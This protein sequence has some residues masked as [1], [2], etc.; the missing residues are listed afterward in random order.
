MAKLFGF[1]FGRVEPTYLKQ[2]KVANDNVSF[3]DREADSTAAVVLATP[4]ST[5]TFVDLTGN[6]KTEAEF[7]SKYREMMNQPEVDN[8]VSEIINE[9]VC[10]DKEFVVKI[11]LGGVPLEEQSK[12]VIKE[13]FDELI[14]LLDFDTMAYDIFKRWYVDGRLYYHAVIDPK[15]PQEGI[16]EFRYID[17]RK[18]REIKEVKQ[19]PVPGGVAHQSAEVTI[20]KN[21]YY[22]YNEKGFTNTGKA[23]V[24]QNPSTGGIRISKDSV[25]HVPSGLTD[26]NG[27]VGLSYLHK[28]IKILNELRTI[29]DAIII[30][31]LARAPERRVWKVDCGTLP[32]MKARQHLQE[33]MNLQKNRLIYDADTGT[34]RD[35][36]KFMCYSLDTKIPLLDGRTL[37]LQEIMKEY[38][39]GKQNWVYS[40]DPI[41]GKFVPGP[42]SW[43]GITKRNSEVVRVTFD[44]GQSVVC[45]PDHKFPVWNKGFIEA[46]DLIGESI[47]PGYRRQKELFKGQHYE[48]IFKND[49]KSW[50]YT[51]REVSRWKNENNLKEETIYDDKYALENKKTIHHRNCNRF[52]NSPNNLV[53]M[54]RYDHLKYHAE[55]ARN[56]F[57]PNK[58]ED[59]TPEWRAK[60]SIAA[61][62]RK[63]TCK[64]WKIKLPDGDEHIIENLNAYCREMNL[65]RTNIKGKFGSKGYHAEELRNHKA[66]SVEYISERIDVGCIT[67]DLDETYH[68]HHTY[69]LDAGVYTK[70]TMMEDY[71]MPVWADGRGTSV[72]ILQGGQ[73][74]GNIEDVVYFQ[75]QLY[76][77]LNVPVD[78]LQ[79]DTPFSGNMQEISRAEIKFNKFITRLRQQFS[80]LF[81][82]CLERHCVLKG[83]MSIEEFK[84]ISKDITYEYANDDHFA[85]LVDQQ[86]LTSQINTYMLMEQTGVIGKYFSNRWVRRNIFKQ[87]E[88]D[89]IQMTQEIIEELQDPLYAPQ[90]QEGGGDTGGGGGEEDGGEASQT[91]HASE[92]DS[93]AEKNVKIENAKHVVNALVNV[94][95]KSPEDE[96]KLKSAAQI[97]AKNT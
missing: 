27:T 32:P 71:W 28:A 59:F 78:R 12:M 50:E 49:T 41:T 65:N 1:S 86:V 4:F 52:N 92:S 62:L 24:N 40:C 30:Y 88:E 23:A 21:E 82:K 61:K 87:T 68:S 19:Q 94:K 64:S 26:P 22:L 80:T 55:Q 15:H 70:N 74:L 47:I 31:R 11:D 97:L 13:Q 37:E 77:S 56:N 83:L 58:S 93:H 57:K 96:K 6:I 89:I 42:V 51:H 33:M 81:T 45:T 63:P 3:I 91:S 14:N 66:I 10:T 16:K 34:I 29:E 38:E 9:A 79:E 7:I 53:L 25:I 85:N 95:K 36:R 48:Q 72:D 18:I 84:A 76:N 5:G 90:P 35:D 46:K 43:A 69:L 75:K 60:L 44:N 73:N 54:N 39:E 67:V 20:T 17:P 2:D 8:A